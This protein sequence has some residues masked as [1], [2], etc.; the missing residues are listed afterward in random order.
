MKGCGLGKMRVPF[1]KKTFDNSL[2]G[3]G[4]FE[5][6]I[7]RQKKIIAGE[8]EEKITGKGGREK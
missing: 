4:N 7:V 6:E 5:R 1:Y 3:R 2:V 8:R